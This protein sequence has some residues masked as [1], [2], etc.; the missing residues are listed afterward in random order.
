MITLHITAGE[1]I[2]IGFFGFAVLF[3]AIMGF[4]T[5]LGGK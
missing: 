4:V 2:L 5:M 1:G 3:F